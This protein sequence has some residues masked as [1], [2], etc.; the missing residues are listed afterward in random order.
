MIFVARDGGV[1]FGGAYTVRCYGVGA[2]AVV[3]VT[4]T[5]HK[6]TLASTHRAF[7]TAAL[8]HAE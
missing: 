6:N 1:Y 5:P 4:T 2:E 8:K 7:G 3:A